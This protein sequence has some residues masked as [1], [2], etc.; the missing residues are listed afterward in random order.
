MVAEIQSKKCKILHL[1]SNNKKYQYAMRENGLRTIISDT[2]LEKDLGVLISQDL[3]VAEQCNKAAKKAMRV[4]GMVRKTFRNLEETTL[5]ILYCSFVRLHL[6]YCIQAWAPYPKK[7]IATLEKVQ[8]RAT[9]LVFR[10]RKLP[11]EKRLRM[12]NLYPLKQRRLRGDLI[13]TF[14]IVKGVED[15]DA[16]VFF[17][18]A[19][20]GTQRDHDMKIFKQRS[21]LNSS[22][23]FFSQKIVNYWNSLPHHVAEADSINAFKNRIDNYWKRTRWEDIKAQG[24]YLP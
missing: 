17:Q 12:L 8:R 9:K 23:K 11:Y 19:S 10:L 4:L 18:R 7:D 1:G 20:T 24:L 6:E 14:K 21:R 13:E 5:K 16:A 22:S 15:V 2:T 3:K